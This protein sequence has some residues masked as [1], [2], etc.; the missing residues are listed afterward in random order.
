MN[1]RKGNTLESRIKT[2]EGLI[3]ANGLEDDV[4]RF[5]AVGAAV[6]EG[7]TRGIQ[8]FVPKKSNAEQRD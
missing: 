2:F 8:D 5:T 6:T 1:Q 7:I 4:K 3:E